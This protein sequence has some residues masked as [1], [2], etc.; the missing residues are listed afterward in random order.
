MSFPYL[1]L[2]TVAPAVGGAVVAF[3]PKDRPEMVKR[4]ALGWSIGVFLIA[5]AM[6]FSFKPAGPRFQFRESY[7]WIPAWD[8]RFTFAA[9][10]IALVMLALIALLVPVVILA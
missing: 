6:W 5:V 2:L 8:A 4:I 9:D 7:R 3:L 10:G 1:S